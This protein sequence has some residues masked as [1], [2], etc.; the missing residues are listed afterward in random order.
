MAKRKP[1]VVIETPQRKV[2]RRR[3]QWTDEQLA[4]VYPSDLPGARSA[5]SKAP[6][7]PLENIEGTANE[8]RMA[9][10]PV[11]QRHDH[12]WTV[13][14]E[15]HSMRQKAVS[16]ARYVAGRSKGPVNVAVEQRTPKEW[17]VKSQ[18]AF[19]ASCSGPNATEE[20][21]IRRLS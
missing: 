19:C 13:Q 1:K 16:Q 7:V 4:S 6:D 20:P 15:V 21:P 8:F 3:K 10:L 5:R 11:P 12:E 18:P 14:P 2:G 17:I 9:G